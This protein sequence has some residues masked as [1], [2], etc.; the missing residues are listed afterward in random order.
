M[1]L[2]DKLTNEGSS[3]SY[4]N[5]GNAA[6]LDGSLD[7]SKLHGD[8]N[9]GPGYSLDG[10]SFNQVN[11][12]YQQYQDGATNFLP[13]PSQLDTN[14]V[15]P[16]GPLK[17]PNIISVNNTFANGTYRDNLPEGAQTF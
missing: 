13:Q 1:G 2:K 17:A 4:N 5:G 7:Q 12:S 16:S 10:S 8:P 3:F 6:T 9:G 14:G 11:N 15:T